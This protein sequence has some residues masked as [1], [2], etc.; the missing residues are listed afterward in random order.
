[1]KNWL[2]LHCLTNDSGGLV[3]A[4]ALLDVVTA[5]SYVL[6][7]QAVDQDNRM[8]SSIET[9]TINIGWVNQ[10]PQFTR[11]LYVYNIREDQV[12]SQAV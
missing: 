5:S 11:N 6:S 8:R 4:Q 12:W 2:P 3:T 1:M 10:V 9:L 7:I